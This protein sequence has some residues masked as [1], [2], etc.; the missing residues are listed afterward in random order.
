MWIQ[1]ARGGTHSGGDI[2]G[3]KGV[4]DRILTWGYGFAA[5]AVIHAGTR[6]FLV[7]PNVHTTLFAKHSLRNVLSSAPGIVVCPHYLLAV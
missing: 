7:L 5:G 1:L 4:N 6:I 3:M 2:D